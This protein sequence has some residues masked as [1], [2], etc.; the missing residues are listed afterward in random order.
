MSTTNIVNSVQG[1]PT[2]PY[3]VSTLPT[4][5]TMAGAKIKLPIFN[6]NRLEDPEQHWYLCDIVWTVRKIQDENIKKA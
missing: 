1:S 4:T 5:N 6:G 3:F 2:S